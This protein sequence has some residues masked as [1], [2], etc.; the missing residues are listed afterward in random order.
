MI[1]R[2]CFQGLASVALL[3]A[4]AGC[5]HVKSDPIR[6]EPIYIEITINHRVQEELDDIFSEIDQASTT[7]EYAPLETLEDSA[8]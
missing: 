6:V 2:T 4:L 7:T 8:Q 5:V 3:A 1:H